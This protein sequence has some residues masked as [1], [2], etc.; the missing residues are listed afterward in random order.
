MEDD[1][2]PLSL[3]QTVLLDMLTNR[4]SCRFICCSSMQDNNVL[5]Q[6]DAIFHC[7]PHDIPLAEMDRY[8]V[9]MDDENHCQSV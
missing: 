5:D 7:I 1:D 6:E 3:E 9:V 2:L 8:D 4:V